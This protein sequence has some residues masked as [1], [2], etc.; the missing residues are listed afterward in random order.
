[1]TTAELVDLIGEIKDVL[2]VVSIEALTVGPIVVLNVALTAALTAELIVASIAVLTT[3]D[4]RLVMRRL[5]TVLVQIVATRAEISSQHQIRGIGSMST[6]SLILLRKE[7][8]QELLLRCL[9]TEV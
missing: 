5:E 4:I 9:T 6:R 8:A 7:S 1:M 2:I 3:R